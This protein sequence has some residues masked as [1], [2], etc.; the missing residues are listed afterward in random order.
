MN[1]RSA[2]ISKYLESFIGSYILETIKDKLDPNQYGA[3]KGLSTIHA[4]IDPLHHL[5][6]IVHHG[7][8]A[9]ICFIDYSKAF[10][11][12]DHNLLIKKFEKLDLLLL[13]LLVRLVT[14]II[15]FAE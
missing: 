13:L 4:L 10:D 6:E 15:Q 11:L 2:T 3:I 9:R 14:Q 12:I 5:H 1:S 8:A 7:S